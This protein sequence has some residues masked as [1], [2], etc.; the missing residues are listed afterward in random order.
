MTTVFTESNRIGN[1]VKW[2]EAPDS[3]YHFELVTVN[4]ASTDTP[5]VGTVLAKV[6][7]TGKYLVQNSGLA[8]GEGLESAGILLGTDINT[9]YAVCAAATDTKV[10]MLARG[11]AHV[12]KAQLGFGVG[13]DTD[14]KKLAEYDR[15]A[16]LGILVVDKI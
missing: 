14:A 10:L 2:L 15:L 11:P 9:P 7:A 13:T 3:G 6:N 1:V 12:S 5:R 16:A 8:S 4:L